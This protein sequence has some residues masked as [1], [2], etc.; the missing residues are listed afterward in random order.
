M[1]NKKIYETVHKMLNAFAIEFPDKR[2]TIECIMRNPKYWM[3]VEL[4][5]GLQ[6][7]AELLYKSGRKIDASVH[8]KEV[9]NAMHRIMECESLRCDFITCIIDEKYTFCN[10]IMAVRL[11]DDI[12]SVA[13]D[14]CEQK[15]HKKLRRIFKQACKNNPVNLPFIGTLSLYSVLKENEGYLLCT[16]ENGNDVF[17]NPSYLIDMMSALPGCIAYAPKTESSPIYF[18]GKNGDGVL[19]PRQHT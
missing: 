4:K 9:V 12:R 18:K 11:D 16:A 17:C 2:E 19:M 10:N 6:L 7:V 13:H 14:M 3:N 15:K 5:Q 8:G 1:K